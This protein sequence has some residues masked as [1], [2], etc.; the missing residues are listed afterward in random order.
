MNVAWIVVDNVWLA[1]TVLIESI[2]DIF[3]LLYI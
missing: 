3:L 1:N 2:A